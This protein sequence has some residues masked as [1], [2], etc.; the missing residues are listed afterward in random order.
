MV[1]KNRGGETDLPEISA[2]PVVRKPLI[3]HITASGIFEPEYSEIHLSPRTAQITQI[4]LELGDVVQPGEII[5]QIDDTAARRSLEEMKVAL[6]R[7]QRVLAQT[8]LSNK[9]D[10]QSQSI[11]LEQAQQNYD[12]QNQLYALEA[13]SQEELNRAR[14]NL[15]TATQSFSAS[16]QRLNLSLGL[17]SD[18]TPNLET[19]DTDA[20]IDSSPDITSAKLALETAADAVEDC[21]IISREGGFIT[22][23][24]YKSGEYVSA[25][26]TVAQVQS[27]NDMKAVITVDEVDIG[28]ISLGDKAELTSDALL[29]EK[30]PAV[31]TSIAPVIETIGNARASLV[32]ITPEDS[33]L[34]LRSGASCL[35]S[36][37][38]ISKGQ[39]L[40]VPVGTIQTD[41]GKIQVFLLEDQGNSRYKLNKIVLETG[42]T[43]IDDVE[44]VDGLEEGNLVALVGKDYLREGL[45]VTLKE[46]LSD[47]GDEVSSGS[48]GK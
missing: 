18:A 2:A 15:A 13:V 42:L 30:V 28:K 41:K 14:D 6:I 38:S 16:R 35:A 33:E 39:A 37:T 12:K 46:E 19:I 34:S 22:S 29:G 3:E 5:L 10:Y 8:L 7:S 40:T 47:E 21:R 24:P 9:L 45:V 20:V 23:L 36:I 4:Y 27:L 43:T 32:E 11:A 1:L 26:I 48:N 25:G 31:V 17:D 44:V